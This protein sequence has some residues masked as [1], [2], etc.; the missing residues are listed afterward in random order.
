MPRF[1]AIRFSA[2]KSVMSDSASAQTHNA[3]HEYFNKY[4]CGDSDNNVRQKVT[5]AS[6]ANKSDISV[7]FEGFS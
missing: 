6:F 2:R 3:L 7:N 5:F 1:R 4:Q